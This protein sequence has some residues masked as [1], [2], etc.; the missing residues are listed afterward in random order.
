MSLWGTKGESDPPWLRSTNIIEQQSF[1][2]RFVDYQRY[3]LVYAGSD[4][5][6]I[7]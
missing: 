6:L 7:G 5:D 3:L 1:L 4:Y 2:F